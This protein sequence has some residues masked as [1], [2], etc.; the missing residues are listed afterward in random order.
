MT[1][2]TRQPLKPV[3]AQSWTV[4]SRP[5]AGTAPRL[6]RTT[7][8]PHT[9]IGQRLVDRG[10]LDPGDLV[11]ALSLQARQDA[12]LGDIL[13]SNGMISEA[14]LMSALT[15]QWA[16]EVADLRRLPPDTRLIDAFGSVRCLRHGVLP[17]QRNGSVVTVATSHPEQFAALRPDLEQVLGP[18]AMALTTES[19]LHRALTD[20]RNPTLAAMAECRVPK[21]LSCRGSV[22]PHK[23]RLLLAGLLSVLALALSFPITVVALLTAWSVL[24]LTAAALLKV[25]GFVTVIRHERTV[26]A[27]PPD[28]SHSAVPTIARLPMVSVMVPLFHEE[29]VV[30][31][32]VD[33]LSRLAYPKE[34]MDILLV[35]EETDAVTA[36]VLR[37]THLPRWMR[38]VTVPSGGVRTK[39]RALNY[40]L[41]FCRGQIVGVWD[42]EDA[43]EPDQLHAVVRRFHE[44]GPEVACLQGRLDYYN[45]RSNWLS[46]CFTVEYASWF[47]VMLP[48]LQR[49]GLALPLGGTTLFFRRAALEKLGGWDA[50]NV[51]E[52]AD[53]GIRLSRMGYRTE[54]VDTVTMEEA[55]CHILPWVKQRSRWLK[56]YAMTWAVHMKAP[57]RL[58]QELGAWKF[59]GF[60]ILFLGTLTQ[61]MLAPVLWSFWLL[62]V[63]LPHPLAG[64]LPPACS[65]LLMAL[66][67]S[68]EL[69][70]ITV[71][72]YAVRDGRRKFLMPWI[73]TM[74]FYFPLAAFASY[75]A[76]YEILTRP[77]FWDKTRHGR[78]DEVPADLPNGEEPQAV[79][80]VRQ[81]PQ[82]VT[83]GV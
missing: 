3:P 62:A 6:I 10:C 22:G 61:F 43:P 18:V 47:G 12:R 38:V 65:Y 74:H 54:M 39:P 68:S 19:E 16:A 8:L 32:L 67:V 27:T 48:G 69:I 42:A 21:D 37:N 2:P 36:D 44:C 82:I 58:W 63:G 81:A 66:F 11:K 72:A 78:Y 64:L 71:S 14:D 5:T 70:N 51:T 40:A 31:R 35:M 25:A 83:E 55:N 4:S 73:P 53:L 7:P 56:G 49:L 13:L 46:R 33:R 9:P 17:W 24:S 57:R 28:A 52:D 60:Q 30:S 15:E 45:A 1:A 29:D 59:A 79:R 20:A 23:A 26:P 34:L 80:S 75:K 77:F 76:F 41:D 50:H